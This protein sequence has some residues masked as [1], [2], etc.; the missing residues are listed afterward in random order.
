[1][2]FSH[3]ELIKQSRVKLFIL[4]FLL[5]SRFL[6]NLLVNLTRIDLGIWHCIH[7]LFEFDRIFLI[8]LFL[9]LLHF[10]I[11]PIL[12]LV[13]ISELLFGENNVKIITTIHQDIDIFCTSKKPATSSAFCWISAKLSRTSSMSEGCTVLSTSTAFLSV[14]SE[15]K[16]IKKITNKNKFKIVIFRW[17]LSIS[18]HI[19]LIII[20]LSLFF[21][22][23]YSEA[24][25]LL[26]P[27]CS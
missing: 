22:I 10:F 15:K 26:L 13:L 3:G 20:S 2:F 27:F 14:L 21:F 18:A 7:L 4:L 23:I 12:I 17:F 25:L 11:K 6:F 5:D 16:K 1:V 9:K 24:I 19:S 8:Y